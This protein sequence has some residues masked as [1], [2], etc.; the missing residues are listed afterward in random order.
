MATKYLDNNDFM[1]KKLK[2]TFKTE[3]GEV[4]TIPK[5]D[6]QMLKTMHLNQVFQVRQ[7][8]QKWLSAKN[9]N[10]IELMWFEGVLRLMPKQRCPKKVVELED[11]QTCKKQSLLKKSKVHYNKN[12]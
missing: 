12:Y 3:L 4:K 1:W 11:M 7:R 5:I 10:S 9:R 2:D 8:T 6:L